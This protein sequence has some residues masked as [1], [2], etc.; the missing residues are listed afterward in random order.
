MQKQQGFT[1]I[2]LMIVVAIIGI[3]AAIAIPQYQ[4]YTKRAKVS[5]VMALASGDKTRISEYFSTNGSMPTAKTGQGA[6]G[7][8]EVAISSGNESDYV[9][10]V[11]YSA[12]G[13]TATLTYP[14]TNIGTGATG[15]IEWKLTANSNSAVLDWTC[16]AT[17]VDDALLPEACKS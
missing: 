7:A 6:T 5:D 11:T 8:D 2:E 13:D 17:D 1:L 3:L 10:T 15:S 14:L 4:N 12:S 9:G 16:T